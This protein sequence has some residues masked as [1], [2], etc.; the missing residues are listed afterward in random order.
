M[1]YYAHIPLLII[2]S[3]NELRDDFQFFHTFDKEAREYYNMKA[4][5]IVVFNSERF[6]T[7]H[8]PKFYRLDKVSHSRE[9]K[10]FIKC[11]PK[12]S[13]TMRSHFESFEG[14]LF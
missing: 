4:G 5:D 7:K 2:I 14:N 11:K 3:G 10:I 8:E 1:H 12:K 13:F 6:Y 9:L